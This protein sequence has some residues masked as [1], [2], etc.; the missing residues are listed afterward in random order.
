MLAYFGDHSIVDI[1][2]TDGVAEESPK[3]LTF[4]LGS[5]EYGVDILRVQEIL[6][7]NHVTR[8]PSVPKFI[9]GVTNLRGLIVPIVDMRIKFDLG[10]PI[11]NHLTT[12]IILNVCR[13]L[14]GLV[15]S[16]VSDVISLRTSD[17]QN[18]TNCSSKLQQEYL[19]GL[20][21]VGERM[22]I[23]INA[24]KLMTSSEMELVDN[25]NGE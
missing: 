23:L 10:I 12:V 11:Y 24:D 8:V 4:M 17:I 6:G 13:R 5:E 3:F 1:E 14:V 7:Y 9:K 22:I 21:S 16:S 2:K 15:V 19:T 20:S 18:I 25:I